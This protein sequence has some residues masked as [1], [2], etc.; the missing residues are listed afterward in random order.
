M[1]DVE[2]IGIDDSMKAR[3]ERDCY[4]VYVCP[5]C[6]HRNK[7]KVNLSILTCEACGL[8]SEIEDEV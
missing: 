4:W 7:T 1:K 8:Q 2:E 3:R 6:F 5:N